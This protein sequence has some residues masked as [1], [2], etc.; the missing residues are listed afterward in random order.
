MRSFFA[1]WTKN[2]LLGNFEKILKIFDANII[3]KLI[4]IIIGKFVTK[5]RSFEITPFSTTIFSASAQ[6]LL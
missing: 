2:K 3:E 6:K 1:V 5:N 4:I